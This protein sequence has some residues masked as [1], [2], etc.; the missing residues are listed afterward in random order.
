MSG[1]GGGD[2]RAALHAQWAG[3][4]PAWADGAEE[5]DAHNAGTAA[6]ML[7]LA[8]IRRGDRVLELAC[9]PGGVGLEAAPLAAPGEVVFSD[10]A[11]EMTEIAAARAAARGLGNVTTRV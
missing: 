5:I 7:D 11:A 3:V 9:G 1:S 10:V 6:A 4:A 8:A 2:L